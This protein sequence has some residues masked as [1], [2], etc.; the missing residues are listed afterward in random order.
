[1]YL[2]D[3]PAY[4]AHHGRNYTTT[5]VILWC[6]ENL[7]DGSFVYYGDRRFEF[8]EEKLKVMFL[9]RWS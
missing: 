3:M 9:L 1:M 5:E 4:Y 6:D 7:P 8:D 2:E